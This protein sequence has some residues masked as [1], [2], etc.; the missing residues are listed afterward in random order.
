M[1]APVP[2]NSSWT[3]TP[4]TEPGWYWARS[5]DDVDHAVIFDVWRDV[6]GGTMEMF[7][8]IGHEEPRLADELA[9]WLWWPIPIQPPEAP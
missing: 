5:S 6:V 3:S 8:A 4:P 1:T 7:Y 9:G 2:T